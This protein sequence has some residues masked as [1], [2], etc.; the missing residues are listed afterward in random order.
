MPRV[1]DLVDAIGC[2]KGK[3]F[4]TMDMMKGYHQG[5]NK[6]ED[7]VYLSLRTFSIAS[8]GF[9]LNKCSGNIPKTDGQ[10]IPKSGVGFSFCLSG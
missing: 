9:L 4:S 1:D 3:Y 7:C 5:K 6:T 2:Q 8:N 10:V